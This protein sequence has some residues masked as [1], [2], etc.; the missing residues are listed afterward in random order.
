MAGNL[1]T[2][3]E[4]LIVPENKTIRTCYSCGKSYPETIRFCP[5]DGVDLEY[6]P[7]PIDDLGKS[8]VRSRKWIA[9]SILGAALAILVSVFMISGRFDSLSRG[10]TESGEI[11]VRT[12]P[13]GA[14]IYL[15]GSQM[16]ATPIRLANIQPGVHVV[17][18]I[19]PGYKNGSVRIE[20]LPSARLRVVWDLVPLRELPK[21]R[22]VA[23]FSRSAQ[24]IDAWDS[25]KLE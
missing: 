12:T 20:I 9:V 25:L 3:F 13:S 11:I 23:E 14:T 4:I 6:A 22:Y 17:R 10:T 21:E 18:A 5:R 24:R 19:Y 7:P 15:D 8:F 1:E 16:G 2:P